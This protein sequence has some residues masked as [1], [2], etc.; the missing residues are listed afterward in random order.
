MQRFLSFTLTVGFALILG[1]AT[2]MQAQAPAADDFSIPGVDDP[3]PAASPTPAASPS[4]GADTAS[5]ADSGS[6]NL[7]GFIKKGGMWMIPLVSLSVIMAGLV[8][9]CFIDLGK[10][11]FYPDKIVTGLKDDMQRADIVH[12]LE[13]AKASP[14]CLGQVI[15]G[16]AE[17]I[18]D[19]GYQVLDDNGLYDAMADASQDFNRGRARTINYLSLV[20]QAAPMLGLLGTVAGMISAFATLGDTGNSNPGE[21]AASISV[22]L[23]TTASGLVIA[24][25]ALFFYAFFRDKLTALVGRTDRHAFSLLNTLRRSIVAQSSGGG[26]SAA[27]ESD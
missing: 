17:Y 21:L 6:G 16:A 20:A 26:A 4:G 9:Y 18:G 1:A 22:A 7:F 2:Q 15:H 10:R 12:A 13:R 19:R 24:L 27:A 25:P 5:S 8:V 11:N 14:T 3:K 23:I